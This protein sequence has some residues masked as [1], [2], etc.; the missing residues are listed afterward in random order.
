MIA[1]VPIRLATRADAAAIAELSR[2]AIEHGL[3]WRWTPPRVQRA[4]DDARTNVAVAREGAMLLGFGIMHY[5][6]DDAAHLQLLA[7]HA[8]QRRAGIGSALLAW[9]EAVAHAA[10]LQR[11]GLE[12][13]LDNVAG[14]C[15]YSEHGYHERSIVARLYSGRL[16]GVRMQKWLRPAAR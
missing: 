6:A 14:R 12:A 16:D 15:F 11:I 2:D 8:A 1:T 4:I 10:G 5:P 9:L 13:R 7:V 3:P